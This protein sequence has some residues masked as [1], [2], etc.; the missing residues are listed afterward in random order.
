MYLNRFKKALIGLTLGGFGCAASTNAEASSVSINASTRSGSSTLS[1]IRADSVAA[2]DRLTKE[3]E[4]N[5]QKVRSCAFQKENELPPTFC[6]YADMSAEERSRATENCI[7]RA[8]RVRT[9]PA[10]DAWTD[11]RCTQALNERRR[12]L[13]YSEL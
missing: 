4:I 13:E 2:L 1:I 12:D 9:V 11:P 7:F 5:D 10:T 8:R 6:F 3:R